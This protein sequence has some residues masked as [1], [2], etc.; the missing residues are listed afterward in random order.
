MK[1]LKRI[2]STILILGVSTILYAQQLRKYEP[3]TEEFSPLELAKFV[4]DKIVD[5]TKFRFKYAIQTPYAGVE[6]IDFGQNFDKSKPGIAYAFSS[7]YSETEQIETF[8]VGCTSGTKIWVNDQLVFSR[9]GDQELSV[10]F[11][12]KTYILPERFNVKLNKGE[13][14]I[15]IKSAYSGKGKWLLLM[16]SNNLGPYAEKGK[17]IKT[18]L[19][20]YAP[21]IN[22]VNWLVLGS[23]ENPDGKG[24]EI[25]YEPEKRIEFHKIYKLEDQ[26]FTW[27]IPRIH[28]NTENPD[29]GKFYAWSYHVGGFIWGLQRLSQESKNNKYADY[30]IKWCEYTLKTFPLAQYQTKELHAVRSLNWGTAGRPML[31]Y[32]SAPSIP[33]MTR[34]IYEESFPLREEYAA[35]AEKIMNYLINGQYR[36]PNGVFARK[37]TISPSVWADDM[38]MGI[39]YLLF[40]AM[41]TN[42]TLLKQ[43]LYDD[44]ANQIIQFNKLLYKKEKKLYMQACYVDRPDEKIP[45]WSRGNGWAI[46]GT[47]EVLQNLPKNHKQYK[48][49][50]DIYH[51]HIKGIVRQQDNEGYWHNILDMPETVRESSGTAIFTLCIARGINNGWLSKKE[52]GQVVE[53]AW[54]ALKSFVDNDGNLNGVKGGTNF[55]TNPEAYAKTPFVKSDTHGILPLL[56]ACIE[57]QHYFNQ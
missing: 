45:F 18:S 22:I 51:E 57:M 37:Y 36:L 46:W 4:A 53:K 20:S 8:E 43:S 31:D 52:Y 38:F 26:I 25:Q 44:A 49:I 33:F 30:A 23:F 54:L 11:E 32:T 41:Y 27:D 14:K 34:L 15:L 1:T 29:G 21:N 28:I 16:Q 10:R 24:L 17:K 9:N 39:P 7:L 5:Q 6:S 42:D 40:S 56:F 48:A 13:N 35:H 2:K 55:S 47:S 19:E 50:L 3:I 12:E